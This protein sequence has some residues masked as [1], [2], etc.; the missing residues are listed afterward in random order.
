[1]KQRALFLLF[2]T[3]LYN[4]ICAQEEAAHW[5]F[6]A[7]A[8]MNF[9]NK[10]N[11][12]NATIGG[13][14]NQSLSNVPS[15][16]NGPINTSEGCF[17]ISTQSG[18]FLLASD[19]RFVY[20]SDKNQM[21]HGKGLKGDAS[22]VQSG[23]VAPRPNHPNRY[24]IITAP[25]YETRNS[26]TDG[27][28][29][30]EVDMEK[31]GGKGD[32]LGPYD[33]SGHPIGIELNFDN[34]YATKWAYENVAVVQHANQIDY[35]LVHRCRD[36]FFVWKITENGINPT[37]VN[38][39]TIGEDPGNDMS[40]TNT[41]FSPDGKYLAS[42]N[43]F[44]GAPKTSI[45]LAEFDTSSGSISNIN[46]LTLSA[47]NFGNQ[48]YGLTFSPNNKYLYYTLINSGGAPA[49]NMQRRTVIS[50]LNNITET[51]LSIGAAVS[52]IQLG[53]DNRIYG[54]RSEN[55][56]LSIILDPD[57][58]S[59][60]LATIP[61][62][63]PSGV[64]PHISL[65]TFAVGFKMSFS[66]PLVRCVNDGLKTYTF[67][68]DYNPTTIEY[69]NIKYFEWNWGD[70]SPVEKDYSITPN[71]VQSRTHEYTKTGKHNIII[72]G[73]KESTP[74]V[75]TPI[76]SSIYTKEIKVSSCIMP[77]NHNISVTY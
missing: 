23:I 31:E 50:M 60:T 68:I 74:G 16:E 5:Y 65:P 70:G 8:G 51:P 17:S 66:G 44:H 7:K 47:S 64:N 40:H 49:T 69:T 38:S 9:T 77:V 61:N 41:R 14:T 46:I 13:S 55:R 53:P 11:A 34:I 59:P 26:R 32:V 22:A 35:W 39:Y 73:Y 15:F 10:Y 12:I 45:I 75:F 4:G 58:V 28:Y 67:L 3:L 25:A 42:S 72:T 63:F 56:D 19:G 30:Y 57:N 2:F 21:P 62:Y 71:T 33:S 43:M 54:I 27:I 18:Q 76:N 36:H 52:N 37:P 29:Y 20:N 24:Y 48:V 1:M 6:G